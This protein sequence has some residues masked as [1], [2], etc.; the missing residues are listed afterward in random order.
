MG[1]EHLFKGIYNGKRVL[2]TGHTGFKGSWLAFWLTK[3]GAEITGY[4]LPPETSPNHHDLLRLEINSVQGD[5]RDSE[6]LERTFG[7]ASPEI[8]FH[9]AAQPF[10]RRSYREPLATFETNVMGTARLLETCRKTP[11]VRAV[12][13]ITSDKCYENREWPWGYRENDPM[14]GHDPYSASKGCTELLSASWRNSFF[15]PARYGTDHHVLLATARAGNVVGGGD[16]GEDRLICDIIRSIRDGK[17]VQIRSPQAVRPWQHVLEPLGGYLRLGQKLL[18]GSWEFAEGWNF[19]PS[20]DSIWT[21]QQVVE[22]IKKEWDAFSY[23]IAQNPQLHEAG[24]LRLDCS[25][26]RMRLQWA[27]VW[28]AAATFEKTIRWY[29]AHHETGAVLT[30]QD[31][32]QYVRDASA[33]NASWTL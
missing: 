14:G 30:T 12:V 24:L 21:V 25:K 22:S 27:P 5:I 15:P 9:L 6:S 17:E 11:S 2:L 31:L 18:E 16:W 20:D 13:I 7:Q 26:A 29:R 3:L 32:D 33:M 4:A 19:G 23:K 1:I 8:V 10:V 28:N